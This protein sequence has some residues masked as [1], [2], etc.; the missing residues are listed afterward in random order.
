MGRSQRF[1]DAL[2]TRVLV[3]DGAMGTELHARGHASDECYESL[4]TK[5]RDAVREVLAAYVNAGADVIETN[6]FRANRTHLDTFG[7]GDKVFEFNYRGARLARAAAGRDVFVAGSVGPLSV[8][9]NPGAEHVSD[10]KAVHT[11]EEQMGALAAG[12]VDL[13]LLETF[14]DLRQIRAAIRAARSA[15]PELP[16]LAQMAFYEGHGSLGGVS[17]GQAIEEMLAEGASGVG[18]NCGRGFADALRVVEKM[19]ALTDVPISVYPN[20]GLPEAREGRLVYRQTPA[21]MADMAERMAAVGVNLIG[22]C[23]GTD[24]KSIAAIA[25]RL[26]GRALSPRV[27]GRIDV[28]EPSAAS[29]AAA[30][31]T[32]PVET[33]ILRHLGKEPLIVAELD[34][35]R[36]MNTERVLDGARK[37]REAGAHLIS[38]AENP[39]ASIRMGNVG[40]AYLVKRDAGAEPLVHFTGRDRNTIGLHSDLMGAAALGVRHVLAVTGDPAGARESGITSVYDVNSIGICK[41]VTAL[42]EGRTLHGVDIGRSAGLTLGVAFNPNFRTMTGQV[43]KLRQKV[44]AGA[45]FALSQLVYDRARMA[46]IPEGV[47]ACGIP[48]LPGVMPL[49][50]HRNALFM[51]HEV[52]GVHLPEDILARMEKHPTGPDA[53]NEGLDIAREMIDVALAAGAPGI[54][55]VTPFQRADLTATLVTYVRKAWKK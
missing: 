18:V 40:M 49:V 55:L 15:A 25:A 3:G 47:R 26:K 12:G 37:L 6:T 48:V 46:E 9:A 10:S 36:G 19:A 8:A 21:Y 14:T 50:S 33:S 22:G 43:K 54:Y 29:A 4:N 41:I 11:Y 31:P 42:N 28:V 38:M 45:R 30:T 53:E 51:H 34:P 17:I 44:D 20:A 27:R 2:R 39:L 13:I 52:P 7:L 23:C 35:P 5:A 32:A 16:V 1:L 24:A